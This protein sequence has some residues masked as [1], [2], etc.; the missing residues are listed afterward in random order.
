MLLPLLVIHTNI[1]VSCTNF[2]SS[3]M[4]LYFLKMFLKPKSRLPVSPQAHYATFVNPNGSHKWLLLWVKSITF[5][6]IKL[7][8]CIT[9]IKILV[10][11]LGNKGLK[12]WTCEWLFSGSLCGLS[13]RNIP[14]YCFFS[15]K[16]RR[17]A[18]TTILLF[19]SH[20]QIDPKVAFPRRAQPKV[21]INWSLT[22]LKENDYVSCH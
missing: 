8:I 9:A 1:I 15:L 19:F 3:W 14:V 5:E 18:L 13:F 20:S 10:F 22:L 11:V 7:W 2:D 16:I 12:W 17:L 6:Y 4:L 21:R